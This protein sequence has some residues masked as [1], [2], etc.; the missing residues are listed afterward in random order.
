MWDVFACCQVG[1]FR[2]TVTAWKLRVHFYTSQNN[3]YNDIIIIII[4]IIIMFVFYFC[5][6]AG[7]A[8]DVGVVK[9]EH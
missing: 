5:I 1:P 3:N 9:P 2:K 8:I 4:I 6:Y 7:F